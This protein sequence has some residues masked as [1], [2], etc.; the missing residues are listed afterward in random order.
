[1]QNEPDALFTRML[2]E[3]GV[4]VTDEAMQARWRELNVE[5]GSQIQ[6]DSKWSPFWRLIS[7]IVTEPCKQLVTLLVQHALPNVFLQYA[8]GQWLDVYAWG[9]DVARKNATAAQGV[10]TFTRINST[11]ELFVPMGTVIE[12]PSVNGYVYRVVTSVDVTIPDGQLIADIPVRAE[13]TG[14]SYNLGPG[15]Y[16]ILHEPLAGIAA[17]VN[18]ADWLVAPGADEESDDALRLRCRNQFSAVGQYHHDAAYT[19]DIA[20]FAGIRTDYLFFEHDAP[21]GPGSA[22]CYVMIESG[23]PSQEFVDAI[24]AH[25]RDSGNHGH[26]DDMLCFP[27]PVTPLDLIVTVYP[28]PNLSAEKTSE[29]LQGVEDM[30]RCAFRENT[31]YAVTKTWPMGRFSFSRLDAELHGRFTDLQSVTFSSGDIVS[32]RDLPVLGS[33]TIINGGM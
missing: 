17:V 27:V 11:G 31:D 22:N 28:L 6:N 32:A 20:S 10:I 30:V 4:P 24:N 23:Q 13:K 14:E 18:G 8:S 7:A 33:L 16:S 19:A 9:V 3:A 21:R 26:G 15:Y 5:Q 12:T 29:L 2:S 1:M 25:V